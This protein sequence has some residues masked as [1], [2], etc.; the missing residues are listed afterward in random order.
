MHSVTDGTNA[1]AWEGMTVRTG[2]SYYRARYYDP[3]TGRF[4][5]EDPLGFRG[6]DANFFRIVQNRSTMFTDPFG[7]LAIDPSF[8]ANCL[9]ALQQALDIVRKIAL[10]NKTCDC[11]Y[12]TIP[13]GSGLSLSNF[14]DD[15]GI[16][17]S[18]APD[19][20]PTRD[21]NGNISVV[22]ANVNPFNTHQIVIR[23][24]SCRMGRWTLAADLVHELVHISKGSLPGDDEQ[25]PEDM[26][27]LY[28]TT[29]P[30]M[31]FRR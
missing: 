16:K 1:P 10:T 4:T 17:I 12:K 5:S 7:L 19:L 18:Y 31:N 24:Y 30:Q 6:G 23:A 22:A 28:G 27:I 15:P 25:L 26:E 2:L 14:L 13:Q 9:P 8:N 20:P 21:R 11:A 3:N 29:K